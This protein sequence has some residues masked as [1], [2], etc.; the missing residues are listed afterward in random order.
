MDQAITSAKGMN[1]K[2]APDTEKITKIGNK[3][4]KT[5]QNASKIKARQ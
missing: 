4:K 5:K 2:R 1:P 3:L